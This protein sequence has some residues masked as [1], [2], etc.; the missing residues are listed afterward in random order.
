MNSDKQKDLKGL[1]IPFKSLKKK[2]WE[3]LE[4]II[5]WF[6]TQEGNSLFQQGAPGLGLYLLTEG[7]V[8]QHHIAPRGKRLIFGL[9]GPGEIIG[10]E[11]LF[12]KEN[13]IA[14]AEVISEDAKVGFL[15]RNNFFEF[16]KKKPSL[17]F[18]F[19]R[20]LSTKAMA[21]KLKLVETSYFG[22]KQR[23]CRFIL[24]GK[25]SGLSLSRSKLAH[26]SGVSY[27][28]TIQVLTELEDRDFIRMDDHAT[29]VEDKEGLKNLINDFPL[30][31]E[32][33]GLL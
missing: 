16:M 8:E 1:F 11:T 30:D 24:E 19:A 2:D 6:E 23:I 33:L 7:E 27:K 10:T 31:I 3:E 21:F 5:S 20:Y 28:T 25:N 13:H 12:N 15:E 18:A 14:T 17:L 4:S 26:L 22:S 29:R 32:E 9:S